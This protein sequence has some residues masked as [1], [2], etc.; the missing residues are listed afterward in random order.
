MY[1]TWSY[2]L[3]TKYAGKMK[4][5]QNSKRQIKYVNTTTN[6]KMLLDVMKTRHIR[7]AGRLMPVISAV[8]CIKIKDS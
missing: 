4:I 5:T 2:L 1:S 6:K 7:I 3:S 8:H